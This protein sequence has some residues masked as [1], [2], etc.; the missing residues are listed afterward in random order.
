MDSRSSS[1]STTSAAWLRSAETVGATSAAWRS[2]R[3]SAVSAS[4]SA[5]A[6][7]T[8]SAATEPVAVALTL[9]EG[10]VDDVHAGQ[11]R[12]AGV[13]VPREG[14]V[15]DD[16]RPAGAPGHRGGDDLGGDDQ[17][18]RARAGDQDVGGGQLVGQ[19]AELRGPAAD[20]GGQP[21]GRGHR[22]A[23]HDDV[24]AAPR[25]RRGRQRA[26]RAGADDEDAAA[27]E[28]AD[29][30]LGPVEG[31][32]HQR[33]PGPVDAG[34]GVHPLADAQRPLGDRVQRAADGA[35]VAGQGVGG[36]QLAEHLGLA[37]DHRVQARG[38]GEE[39]ADGL[40]LVVDGDERG[41][42]LHGRARLAREDPADVGDAAVE[43]LDLGEDLDPVA[44]REHQRLA[45]VVAADEL[46]QGL[47]PV[48]GAHREP[49][50]QRDG[51][52]LVADAHRQEAHAGSPTSRCWPRKASTW[53]STERSTLR[54]STSAGA[55]SVTGAKFRML[56][57]PAAA[58][59]SQT[60]CA[61]S[62]GVVMTPMVAPVSRDDLL[63]LVERAHGV[64]ADP[65]TDPG[66]GDVEQADELE[67]ARAEAGVVGQGGP[68]VADAD[69]HAGPRPLDAQDAGDPVAQRADLV[70]DAAHAAGAE[71]GQ[72]LA[73]AGGV[74]PGRR[75]EL[76]GGHG[77]PAAVGQGAE[78]PQVHGQ[79][80][81]G[82]L[83]DG[84]GP[85]LDHMLSTAVARDSRGADK[86]LGRGRSSLASATVTAC[87]RRNKVAAHAAAPR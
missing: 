60:D 11:A 2:A 63:Q 15:D 33:G 58:M 52:G 82:G 8:S 50:E 56:R 43:P 32:R 14:Q 9:Q 64:A 74:D 1:A 5:W 59:R 83:R 75:G 23:A 67:A 80:G 37:D 73:Q 72:V 48:L 55:A 78:H 54:T 85:R 4:M 10:E 79:A 46:V 28:A 49:L 87:E 69:E 53:S 71:V 36:A 3:S 41:E 12:D 16:E 51:C 21:V 84:P 29:A 47:D 61:T 18:G 20:R 70:A 57:T 76:A 30:L 26:H 62:A 22:P 34:L 66:G 13:D 40:V 86:G 31:D 17:P 65:R 38:D 24:R 68:E 35:L 44:R 27:L 25:Q 39:V 19:P 45:D 6:A 77:A 81:D 7:A 42:L